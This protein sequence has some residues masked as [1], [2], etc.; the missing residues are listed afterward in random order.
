M[1]NLRP[2]LLKFIQAETVLCISGLAAII[3]MFFVPPSNE[4]IAYIDFRV[5][6]LL[7][8]LMAVVAGFNQT[9]V[10]VLLSEKILMRVANIRSI[11]MVLVLLCFFSSM[12]I[13]NDVALI[14][15]VPFAILILTMT[16]H[17]QHLILI[18]VLQTIA[19]NLGSMLTPVGNPQNLYL[20]SEYS[21]SILEFIKITFP[22]TLLS[23]LLLCTS[24][25][26]I[27]KEHIS[28][29]LSNSDKTDKHK[30]YTIALYSSLFLVCL[31]CV[32]RMIDYRITILVV[33][34]GILFFD[35]KVIKKVDYSLLLTFVCFFVFVGN[36]GSLPMIR[37][38]IASLLVG[39]ELIVSIL[40]SQV[41]SNV[42]AAV[43]LSAFTDDYKSMLLGTN[44][45]GLGTLVASLASLIS[46]KFYSRT[47][48]A[49]P[50]RYLGTFTLYN[51]G[52]LVILCLFYYLSGT[53][54]LL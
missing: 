44:L 28:F 13:T 11:A 29:T 43:L 42:P 39:R 37:D 15:F 21:I 52:F 22:Y 25:M 6:G 53:L 23:L 19:A 41:I 49:N 10:F 33:I 20:Y 16:G 26:L 50:V 14:T 4:Y 7:F 38:F 47:D 36:I 45:G 3:T 31:A 8:C 12:W 34:L 54:L 46:Y 1:K 2:M 5:L 30:P 24:V 51:V 35:R 9:G 27:P 48:G 17:T 18:V 40:A 32:L